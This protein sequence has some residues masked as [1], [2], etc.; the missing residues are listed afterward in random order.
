MVD[1]DEP[2]NQEAVFN[3]VPPIFITE[4]LRTQLR[5]VQ[6]K[7][8]FVLDSKTGILYTNIY[9][10]P[11]MQ[12]YFSFQ[13][14]V[15]DSV[16]GHSDVANVSVST[17]LGQ[18]ALLGIFRPSIIYFHVKKNRCKYSC[19]FTGFMPFWERNNEIFS[20]L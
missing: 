11:D 4:P 5:G 8:P 3:I 13:I 18:A 6:N 9:F 15:N 14:K 19:C 10:Q 20:L 7:A 17:A 12:G 1:P 16:P 2:Q